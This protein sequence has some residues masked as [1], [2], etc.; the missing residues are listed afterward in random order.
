MAAV[1]NLQLS[2][3]VPFAELQLKNYWELGLKT[4]Q[5]AG[6]YAK[7]FSSLNSFLWFSFL[8]GRWVEYLEWN[9]DAL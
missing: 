5:K 8:K 1:K 7:G 6:N 4:V 2:H 3:A 9:G